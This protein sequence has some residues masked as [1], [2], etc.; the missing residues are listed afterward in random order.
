MGVLALFGGSSPVRGALPEVLAGG[1][2]GCWFLRR[3]GGE[4]AVF[5]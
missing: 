4:M 3:P 5:V 2:S 1:G